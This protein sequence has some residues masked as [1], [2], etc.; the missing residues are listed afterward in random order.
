MAGKG[1]AFASASQL[2][3]AALASG[4]RDIC[5]RA[6]ARSGARAGGP[7]DGYVIAGLVGGFGIVGCARPG[8]GFLCGRG[9]ICRAVST[10]R[11]GRRFCTPRRRNIKT[12]KR[13]RLFSGQRFVRPHD[14]AA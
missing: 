9:R 3:L 5:G 8:S 13:V 2:F 12:P 6:L 7:L 14:T 11:P 10:S 1:S 4:G